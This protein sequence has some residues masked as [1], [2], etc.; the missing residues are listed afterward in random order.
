MDAEDQSKKLLVKMGKW[1]LRLLTAPL[2]CLP[3]GIAVLAAVAVG[4]IAAVTSAVGASTGNSN[5]TA[6][7]NTA[8]QYNERLEAAAKA[9]GIPSFAPVLRGILAVAGGDGGTDVMRTLW[10]MEITEPENYTPEQ[11]IQ[12]GT[13]HFAELLREARI[14]GEYD[15]GMLPELLPV[16]RI[17]RNGTEEENSTFAAQMEAYLQDRIGKLSYPIENHAVSSPFGNRDLT[18]GGSNLNNH[19]GTDFAAPTGTPIYASTSGKVVFSGYLNNT[20]GYAVKIQ[21]S[22]HVVTLYAHCSAVTAHEGQTVR[23]GDQIAYVGMSGVATGPHCH[24]GL[25]LDGVPV[26]PMEYL[27][28]EKVLPDDENTDLVQGVDAPLPAQ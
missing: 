9:S 13:N 15:D 21:W 2:G 20:Y 28:G 3:R 23:R 19:L 5:A 1:L 27:L 22:S 16:F 18:V 17:Y 4:I 12:N 11:S 8:A 10:F 26:D 14:S 24:L 7:M 25:Y 6:G